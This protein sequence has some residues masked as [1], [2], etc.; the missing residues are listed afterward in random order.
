MLHGV[1]HELEVGFSW[2]LI[3]RSD[4]S[5]T[6]LTPEVEWN[7]KLAVAFSI[8]DE[9]FL[10]VIDHRSGVNLIHNIVYNCG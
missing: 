1:K 10:P 8:M 9:C 3:R 7:S 5:P 6:E 4:I 2:T